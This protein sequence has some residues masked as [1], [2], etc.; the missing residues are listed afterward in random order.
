M[1][2]E[3]L[4]KPQEAI[5]GGLF[6]TTPL[7]SSFD[8][9]LI[10]PHIK[11]AELNYVKPIL[12]NDLYEEL[13]A[14]QNSAISNYNTAIGPVVQKFPGTGKF[15]VYEA[16]WRNILFELNS[17]CVAIQ[18]LP[19]IGVQ[20]GT[21]GIFYNNSE[22]AENAGLGGLKY[23]L[24]T[25]MTDVSSL[26]ENVGEYLCNNAADFNEQ[27]WVYKNKCVDCTDNVLLNGGCGCNG[28]CNC[29]Y[30]YDY[31]CGCSTNNCECKGLTST[32]KKRGARI[33]G[34]VF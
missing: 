29:G 1:A 24:D 14:S 20:T 15:A 5:N 16:L 11:K 34:I 19:F 4:I 7:N 27:A 32:M 3:T 8:P 17:N 28:D 30:Y 13:V 33:G 6:K 21:N 26:Q 9:L 31:D 10:A 23:L 12:C 22:Y 2:I 18:A 25:L